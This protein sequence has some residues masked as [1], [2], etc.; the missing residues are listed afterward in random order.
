MR[1]STAGRAWM[2]V[3]GAVASG[4]KD[5]NRRVRAML[6]RNEPKPSFVR[7]FTP[8][9]HTMRPKTKQPVDCTVNCVSNENTRNSLFGVFEDLRN[10]IKTSV[11]IL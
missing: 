7:R 8:R 5:A 2:V 4:L 3:V 9:R 6:R 10:H 1:T 11:Q